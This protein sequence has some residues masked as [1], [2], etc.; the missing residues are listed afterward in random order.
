MSIGQARTVYTTYELYGATLATP[1]K[2]GPHRLDD[3]SV[4]FS[5]GSSRGLLGH[6]VLVNY[7]VFFD[8]RARRVRFQL[9]QTAADQ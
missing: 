8:Q 3:L 7:V 4:T 2:L 1:L 6:G 9:P 5:E